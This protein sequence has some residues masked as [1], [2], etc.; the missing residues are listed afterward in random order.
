MATKATPETGTIKQIA[1]CNNC[2]EAIEKTPISKGWYHRE[3]GRA[4]C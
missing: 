4:G 2:D 1:W 3:T